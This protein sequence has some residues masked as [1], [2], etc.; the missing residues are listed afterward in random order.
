MLDRIILGLDLNAYVLRLHLWSLPRLSQKPELY[1]NSCKLPS[2][3]STWLVFALH[4]AEC[5]QD[6]W[7]A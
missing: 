5:W 3:V 7:R 2:G 4:R 1:I 6:Q